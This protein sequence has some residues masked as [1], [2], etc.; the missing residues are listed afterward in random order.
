MQPVMSESAASYGAHHTV[1]PPPPK[2]RVISG[3][4]TRPTKSTI[5]AT[6]EREQILAVLARAADDPSY[7]AELTYGP[8]AAL[9]SY[10]LSQAARGALACGD[11][12]W[13]EARVGK[14]D[15]HMRT[16]LDCRLQQEIW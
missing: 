7:I 11:V 9:E 2:L 12:R 10:E 3:T 14:L 15:A 8:S 1:V 13:I 16:W 6:T 4:A 5:D